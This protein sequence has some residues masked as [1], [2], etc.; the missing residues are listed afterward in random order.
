MI[1]VEEMLDVEVLVAELLLVL[2]VEVLVV[3]I[4]V[5]LL[6]SGQLAP[7]QYTVITTETE[8]E[9]LKRTVVTFTVKMT[10]V[11]PL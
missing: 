6:L 11:A 9:G 2:E 5:E 10:V 7:L 1:E 3:F 8:Y 4:V